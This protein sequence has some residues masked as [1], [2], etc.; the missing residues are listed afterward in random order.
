MTFS[1]EQHGNEVHLFKVKNFIS[2]DTLK[3]RENTDWHSYRLTINICSVHSVI[4]I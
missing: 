3:A 1:P 2:Q 4:S